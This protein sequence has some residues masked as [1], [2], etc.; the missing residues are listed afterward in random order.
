MSSVAI[1]LSKEFI[2]QAEKYA[3][4]NMRTVPSKLNIGLCSGAV[5]RII[6]ICP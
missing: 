1:R 2:N 3:K 5:R 6:L 4:I